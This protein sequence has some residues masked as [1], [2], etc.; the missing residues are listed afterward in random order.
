MLVRLRQDALAQIE[1]LHL[2]VAG[3]VLGGLHEYAQEPA[4]G[5]DLLHPLVALQPVR[6]HSILVVVAVLVLAL[7]DTEEVELL[8]LNLL[9][10]DP[11]EALEEQLEVDAVVDAHLNESEGSDVDID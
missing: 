7:Q 9:E 4:C 1:L 2:V 6:L 5:D 8:D 11:D 10:H 3:V